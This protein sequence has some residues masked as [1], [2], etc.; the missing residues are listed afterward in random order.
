MKKQLICCV[1]GISLTLSTVALAATSAIGIKVN[2]SLIK[3]DVPPQIVNQR[4][5]VPIRFVAEALGASVNWDPAKNTV[6]INSSLA[7][8]TPLPSIQKSKTISIIVDGQQIKSD[9]PPQII[10]QRTMVPI[11][12]VAEALGAEVNWDGTTQTVLINSE[13]STNPND[14]ST[15]GST[16]ANTGTPDASGLIS[17]KLMNYKHLAIY[18]QNT[19]ATAV[20]NFTVAVVAKDASGTQI[21]SGSQAYIG[22]LDPKEKASLVVT[23]DEKV[24]NDATFSITMTSEP[25]QFQKTKLEVQETKFTLDSEGQLHVTGKVKNISNQG[26]SSINLTSALFDS[27]GK[28]LGCMDGVLN[29]GDAQNNPLKPG[30]V[31]NFDLSHGYAEN[32]NVEKHTIEAIVVE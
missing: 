11:R 1:L 32:I 26:V 24:P 6:I 15:S 30:E 27:S 23:F 17:S 9:V 2:G 18:F 20:Q 14:G 22:V 7:Q 8:N 29:V 10:N 5:L 13:A 3:P 16:P 31:Y 12:F 19:K 21:A 28:F 25:T 4:T